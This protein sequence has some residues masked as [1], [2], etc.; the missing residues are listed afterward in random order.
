MPRYD[1]RCCV[2][3]WADE[4]VA[5]PHEA[6]PCPACGGVTERYY[7][8]GATT[9]GVVPD[10]FTPRWIEN[11]GDRPVYVTSRSDLKREMDARGLMPMVRHVG[12]QGSDKSPH[13]TRWV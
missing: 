4:I 9:S 5:R 3:A 1:Q 6:P 11:L 12:V 13:T 10:E 2:C 7:P 8:I